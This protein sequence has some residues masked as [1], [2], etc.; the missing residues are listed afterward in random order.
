MRSWIQSPQRSRSVRYGVICP[1]WQG[2]ARCC[3]ADT[4]KWFSLAGTWSHLVPNTGVLAL[5]Y[6]ALYMTHHLQ[7]YTLRCMLRTHKVSVHNSGCGCLQIS[8]NV[9]RTV[10]RHAN[11]L[12]VV[13]TQNIDHFVIRLLLQEMIYSQLLLVNKKWKKMY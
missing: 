8:Q 4:W 2:S 11:C 6:F 13:A 10:F 3:L 12:K 9:A 1:R 5:C 7:S